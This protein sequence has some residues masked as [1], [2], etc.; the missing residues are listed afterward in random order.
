MTLVGAEGATDAGCVVTVIGLEAGL[1]PPASVFTTV[2][3]Y[4]VTGWSGPTR[5]L[6]AEPL[7]LATSVGAVDP[8]GLA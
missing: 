4:V 2:I 6:G 1:D 5:P 8:T 3:W 7:T